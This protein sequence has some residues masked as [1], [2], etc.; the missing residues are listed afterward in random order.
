MELTIQS[1]LLNV[2]ELQRSIEFYRDVFD[3]RLQ[4]EGDRVAVIMV[5]EQDRRQVLTLREVGANAYHGG[6]GAV[7]AR[8]L[9]F[10][11]G[12][13]EELLTIE[14]RLVD[15]QAFVGQRQTDTYRAVFGLDPDRIE[16]AASFGLT[17]VPIRSEDWTKI[18]ELIYAIE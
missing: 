14:Q 4:A 12:T 18:D 10:E 7:G 13:F 16:V 15:R 6:R 9:A 2:T 5:S 1:V 11:V 3:F 8:L 17:G